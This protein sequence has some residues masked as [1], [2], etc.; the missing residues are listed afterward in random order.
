MEWTF[1]KIISTESDL[2]EIMGQP[3]EL[4]TR[5]TNNYLDQHSKNFIKHSPFIIIGSCDSL[6]NFDLSPKGDPEGF[7]KVLNDKL[8]A[9]PDRLGNRRADT[10][11]NILQNP[12]IG[13]I[14]LIPGI[15]ETLRVNGSAKIV[16]D[17]KLLT[18]LSHKG[19]LP[20]FGLIVQVEE[21]FMHCAKCI[22]RS[23]LWRDV[24]ESTPR[25]VPTLAQSMVDNGR[26]NKSYEQMDQIIKEDEETR[27]Y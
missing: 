25:K 17:V 9:I 24:D 19:K 21:V 7:V 26:L 5:K 27:L 6:S 11:T 15:K 12:N 18:L 13:L 3:S 20:K 10:F 8:L 1:E 2:R 16:T 22:I 4:V 23:D 14:F